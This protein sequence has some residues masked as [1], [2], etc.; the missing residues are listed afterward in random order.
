MILFNKALQYW[1]GQGGVQNSPKYGCSND[2]RHLVVKVQESDSISAM[3]TE[4][5]LWRK[6]IL[7]NEFFVSEEYNVHQWVL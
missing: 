3:E 1:L 4:K 2:S 7:F 5:C 6:M